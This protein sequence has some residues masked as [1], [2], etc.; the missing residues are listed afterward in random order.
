M[1][2]CTY[3]IGHLTIIFYY[4]SIILYNMQVHYGCLTVITIILQ[5]N[6]IGCLT[7]ITQYVNKIS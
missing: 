5:S 6:T 2:D 1:H 4:I 3:T 7:E